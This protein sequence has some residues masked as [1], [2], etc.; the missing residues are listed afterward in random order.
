[1]L[2]RIV[3]NP[4][5]Y[6]HVGILPSDSYTLEKLCALSDDRFQEMVESGEIHPGM[7]R[8]DAVRKAGSKKSIVGVYAP[9]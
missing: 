9:P 5:L 1:M 4:R 6:P 2:I 8:K 7:K 3:E